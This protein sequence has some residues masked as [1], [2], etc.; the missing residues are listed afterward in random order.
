[1]RFLALLVAV[2]FLAPL[3][4]QA[5]APPAVQAL[6]QAVQALPS[7]QQDGPY[8]LWE[9]R[10]A[11]VLRAHDGQVEE[12]ALPAPYRLDLP[13]LPALRLDP[14]PPKAARA[15]FPLPRAIAAVSDVHGNCA[16]LAQLLA[17][18][19]IIGRDLRWTFGKGHLVVVGD[20][21]DRGAQVTEALWLL[22][23]LQQQAREAGGMVHV[24][25]GNHEVMAL[26][27]DLRY[28][29]AKYKALPYTTPELYNPESENGRWLRSLPV[30]ARLGDLLFV[31][32]G[33]SPEFAAAHPDLHAVNAACRQELLG[34]T[35]PMLGDQGPLWYRGLVPGAAKGPEPSEEALGTLLKTYRCRTLVV[36]HTTLDQITAFHGAR[37]YGID[38]GLK[39][40]KPGELWLQVN[41]KRFR[42]LA[43][44][45]RVPLP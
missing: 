30:M 25:L 43:D 17:A 24:L 39:D 31:H 44:G 33:P 34:T 19:G 45:T 27:G 10:K 20:V 5:W 29:N 32:G 12:S 23:S 7:L 4:L 41:G 42:G 9:G 8:V 14:A 18:Q 11:K 26:K 16:G 28:L 13:G 38:A 37:V 2:L 15:V 21:F 35:G 6:P 40:G 3:H 36:G 22:R 1:M